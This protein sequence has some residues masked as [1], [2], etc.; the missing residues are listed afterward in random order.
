L[1]RELTDSAAAIAHTAD[2]ADRADILQPLRKA[3]RGILPVGMV[4]KI[5]ADL[6]LPG[7]DRQLQG[8]ESQIGAQVISDLPADDPPGKQV[9]DKRGIDKTAGRVRI[10]DIGH[11]A[12][13]GRGRGDVPVHQVSNLLP[14]RGG[15]VVRG[16]RRLPVA[17][18]MPSSRIS[19][20]TVHRAAPI[21]SRRSCSHT[22]RAP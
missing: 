19:R 17:P 8:A 7:E 18:S 10:S 6:A 11:P 1:Y 15:T 16:L 4:D 12:A 5:L 20:S 2:R 22:F 3:D 9:C 14:R 13:L 21:P